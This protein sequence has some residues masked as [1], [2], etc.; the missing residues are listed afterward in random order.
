MVY[1]LHRIDQ[2]INAISIRDGEAIRGLLMLLG[3]LG[4]SL[5]LLI[6]FCHRKSEKVLS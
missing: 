4:L 3:F 1:W 6:I 5:L 2:F